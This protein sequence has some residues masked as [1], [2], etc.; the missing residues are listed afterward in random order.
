MNDSRDFKDTKSVRSGPSHNAKTQ[1]EAARYLEYAW[2]IGKLFCKSTG[3]FFVTLSA[4]DQSLDSQRDGR[5]ITAFIEWTPNTR[6]NLGSEISWCWRWMEKHHYKVQR[7]LTSSRQFFVCEVST[8]H[9]RGRMRIK[10]QFK[11][12]DASEDRQPKIHSTPRREDLQRIMEQTNRLQISELHFDK[13]P[14]PTTFACWKIRFKTE[15][16]TCSQ[17][18][19]EAML[20]IQ[21]VEMVESLDDLK[22][23]RSIRK[24]E[25]LVQILSYLTQELLQHWTKSYRIPAARK[26]SVWRKWKLKKKT[27]SSEEDRSLTKST[28]TSGSLEQMILTIIMPTYLQ[29]FFEMMIV[30]NSIRNGTKFYYQ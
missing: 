13:F 15:V 10:L 21:E 8:H 1:W 11:I 30:R 16:C 2:Y 4:R 9:W 5:H 24:K 3:V 12:R 18:P 27:A 25:L 22:S 20:W 19:T 7:V 29:L 14:T 26:R 17:F 6:H 23:S 28:S